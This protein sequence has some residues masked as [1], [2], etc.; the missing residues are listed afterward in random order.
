MYSYV[1]DLNSWADPFG[2]EACSVNLDSG[3]VRVMMDGSLGVIENALRNKNLVITQTAFKEVTEN[4]KKY[5]RKAFL[6]NLMNSRGIK[7]K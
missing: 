2:L 4:A 1:Y 3:T 7:K 5:G 6:D